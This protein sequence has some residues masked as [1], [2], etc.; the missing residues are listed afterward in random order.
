MRA[1]CSRTPAEGAGLGSVTP[2]LPDACGK[3][4]GTAKDSTGAKAARSASFCRRHVSTL[5]ALIAQLLAMVGDPDLER[6]ASLPAAML[7]CDR[8]FPAGGLLGDFKEVIGGKQM[9]VFTDAADA[10]LNLKALRHESRRY[11]MKSNRDER[12]HGNKGHQR[13]N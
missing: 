5:A 3:D 2:G 10:A 8:T 1:Q 9:P 7:G 11:D 12:C 4:H 6:I 13:R